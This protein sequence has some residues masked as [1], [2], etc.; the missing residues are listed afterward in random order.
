[1]QTR[2][3]CT[4]VCTYVQGHR[5]RVTTGQ[6]MHTY[7]CWVGRL[8]S[9]YKS[10]QSVEPVYGMRGGHNITVDV[11]PMKGVKRTQGTVTLTANYVYT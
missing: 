4:Y 10:L 9:T 5:V 8:S 11:M 1:M 3:V 2:C 7:T 6:N